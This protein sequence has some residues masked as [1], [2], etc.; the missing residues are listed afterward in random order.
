MNPIAAYDSIRYQISDRILTI[1]LDRPDQLNAFTV[2][3]SD[4]LEDAFHRASDDDE[5]DA[6]VV[7]GAGRAFCAGMDLTGDGNVFGLDDDCEPTLAD[8]AQHLEEPSVR[9]GVRDPAGRVTLAVLGCTKPVIAA[10][11]GPAVGVGVTMTL[12]M[13]VR[14]ASERARVG[15]VFGKLGV[16]AEGCSTWLL[17]RLVGISR[18]LEWLY[19]ADVM[20]VDEAHR[21]GLVRSVHAH[22]DLLPD[23][24]ALAKSF[25]AGRSFVSTALMRQMIYRNSAHPDPLQAHL[26]ESLAML[27]TRRADGA[28]GVRAFRDKR[29]PR[30]SR[31]GPMPPFYPWW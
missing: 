18:A 28:E 17:P 19:R 6:V 25:T 24:L 31:S 5:V 15:F 2:A 12:A 11:N 30:F 7:T 22:D 26:V 13:D 16:V 27:H 10:I 21:A 9:H 20:D 1:T 8:L 4:E 29:D 3:M 23:A 14:L